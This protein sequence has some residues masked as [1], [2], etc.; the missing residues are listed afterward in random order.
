[1]IGRASS[2]GLLLSLLAGSGC[3]DL[4]NDPSVE[5]RSI[6]VIGG[7]EDLTHDSVVGLVTSPASPVASFCT[8]TVIAPRA[9]LTAAH[10]VFGIDAS[11]LSIDV[12][13]SARFP[14]KTVAVTEVRVHPSYLGTS[15]DEAKAGHD[16]ALAFV[17]SDLA[18]PAV[19]IA[20]AAPAVPAKATL[21]GYGLTSGSSL[22]TRGTRRF[23]EVSLQATC[24]LLVQFG[25]DATNACHG[26]SGG[27]L[28]RLRA[29]G[30]AEILG[31]VSYGAESCAPPSFAT[32]VDA[33]SA[34]IDGVLAADAGASPPAST[35]CPPG[36]MM[37]AAVDSAN[38]TSSLDSATNDASLAVHVGGGGSCSMGHAPANGAMSLLLAFLVISRTCSGACSRSSGDRCRSARSSRSIRRS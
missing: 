8:A 9:V 25:D 32:R 30:T 14:V 38:D 21:V 18:L 17:E 7:G 28:L 36:A 27:P 12:G 6:A 23:A 37:D 29:D 24:S 4:S 15:L 33:Y 34:W 13:P 16:I 2:A 20:R 10:C 1:M 5:S 31:V 3:S 26:D 11:F 19:S 35:D 22:E